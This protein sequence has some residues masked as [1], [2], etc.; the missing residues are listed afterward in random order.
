MP[1]EQIAILALVQGLAEFLP[2]SSSGHLILVPYL[3]GWKDQGLFLDVAV[4]L[5][6]LAAVLAYFWRDVWM[7]CRDLP[8]LFKGRVRPGARM[9]LLILAATLPAMAAGLAMRHFVG[10]SWRDPYVVGWAMT[11]FA[12]VLYVVDRFGLTI[13]RVEHLTMMQSL[14]VGLAQCLAFVPGTSRTGATMAA[15]RFLGFERVEA[16][17]FSMLISIPAILAAGGIEGYELYQTPEPN[18]LF[19]DA[20]L[21]AGLS[22]L[23][24]L[25][26]IFFLMYWLKRASFLPFV[27][28]RLLMGGGLLIY[29][30]GFAP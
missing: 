22:G 12:L 9:F 27:L 17:R 10:D 19:Q 4:H 8:S 18:A 26:A 14:F 15:A 21:A 2:I 6:T 20:L 30:Y 25:L 24:G 28:Y 7:M 1:P 3:T 13:W 23:F 16:T 29:L 5:G 11:G